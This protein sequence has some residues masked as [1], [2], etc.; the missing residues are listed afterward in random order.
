MLV[1]RR[2][3]AGVA[4]AGGVASGGVQAQAPAWPGG[5]SVTMVVGFRPVAR[6]MFLAAPL[7]RRWSG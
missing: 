6:R 1:R 7:L 5:R 3:L 4:V 2:L